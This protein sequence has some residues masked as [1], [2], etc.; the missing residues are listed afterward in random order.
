[1]KDLLADVNN[2]QDER[3]ARSFFE[4]PNEKNVFPMRT[5]CNI[6]AVS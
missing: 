6:P 5:L 4:A 2:L 3:S 1:M